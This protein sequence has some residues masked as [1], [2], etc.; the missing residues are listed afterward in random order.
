METIYLHQLTGSLAPCVATIGFFDGVHLGH[1][2]IIR[3]VVETARREGLLSAVVTFERHPRQVLC[4][5]WRP[6]LIL[7]Y[8]EKKALLSE[9]CIDELVVL[10]FDESMAALSARTFM[11]DILLQRLGV[12]ILLTGYDNH[13]GH[14]EAGC[15]EGFDDYVVY[16]R[17]MGMTVLR[18]DPLDVGD[19]RVSS[20]KVRRLLTNGDVGTA[21]RCLGRPYQLTGTVIS[22]EHIGTSMGFPTANLRLRDS[23]KLIPAVGV[24]AVRVLLD[25]HTEWLNGMMN[26]GTRPTFGGDHQTLEVHVFDFDGN[27]YGR[28]V[29]VSFVCRLRP[30]MKFDS[31]EEL[32]VQLNDDARRAEEIL[33]QTIEK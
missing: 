24:Y 19:I 6:Q 26:I 33:N 23:D 27:L 2:H 20:S 32:I 28:Q 8:E 16:G 3:K 12:R 21:W 9:T 10:R 14:R 30:E 31:R 22:G 11:H 5:D 25:G 15:S 17:D 13:F 1:R 29:C 7:T 4:P 18:G